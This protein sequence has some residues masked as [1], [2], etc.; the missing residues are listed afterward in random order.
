MAGS[1][2]Y[3]CF[4][5]LVSLVSLAAFPPQNIPSE[6]QS[7]SHYSITVNGIFRAAASF[8]DEYNLVNTTE[9]DQSLKVTMYFG[10]GM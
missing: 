4:C 7:R 8:I 1:Y 2:V 3:A 6:W 5:L 10:E 9:T